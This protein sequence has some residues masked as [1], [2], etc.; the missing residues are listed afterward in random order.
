MRPEVS[1]GARIGEA[2]ENSL[3]VKRGLHLAND[4]SA[5]SVEMRPSPSTDVV[6]QIHCLH[7][8]IGRCQESG[9]MDFYRLEIARF[10]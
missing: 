1:S 4:H 10:E 2:L 5:L 6:D 7:G 8:S 3:Q 9:D